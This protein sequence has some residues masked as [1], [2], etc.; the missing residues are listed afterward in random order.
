MYV[1]RFRK[2]QHPNGNVEILQTGVSAAHCDRAANILG[3]E[4]VRREDCRSEDPK[5]KG[6][7]GACRARPDS[8][9]GVG[10]ELGMKKM[11]GMRG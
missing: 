6:S 5:S 3:N 1:C 8:I 9:V 10:Q 4:M 11:T 2:E 7:E